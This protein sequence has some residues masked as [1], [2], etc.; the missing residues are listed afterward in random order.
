MRMLLYIILAVSLTMVTTNCKNQSKAP[1][2]IVQEQTDSILPDSVEAVANYNQQAFS[3]ILRQL[4][5][6]TEECCLQFVSQQ[7]VPENKNL[8]VWVIPKIEDEDNESLVLDG[9]ILLTDTETGEIISKCSQPES[10]VSD[11]M[12]LGYVVIDTLDLRLNDNRIM[13][14]I[15]TSYNGSSAVCPRNISSLK[16]FVQQEDKLLPVFDYCSAES[17]GDAG[18]S[19]TSWYTEYETEVIVTKQKSN[20]FYDF[21]LITN[22]KTEHSKEGEVLETDYSINDSI[23]LFCYTGKE[24]KEINKSDTAVVYLERMGESSKKYWFYY[25]KSVEQVYNIYLNCQEEKQTGAYLQS[26]M[27]KE[28]PRENLEYVVEGKSI[29]E[30][31]LGDDLRTVVNYNHDGENCLIIDLDDESS[32]RRIVITKEKEYTQLLEILTD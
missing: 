8:S 26:M 30:S 3:A 9:F 5:L 10:W 21:A 23:R 1:E 16:L 4:N 6:K 25:G 31:V 24:Y 27:K 18:D 13:F 32:S 29:E 17:T 19:N 7:K 2:E 14:G 15:Q 20:G 12:Q 28:I 11:A 22:S